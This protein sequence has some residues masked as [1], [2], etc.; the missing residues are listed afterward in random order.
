[1]N[2]L[3]LEASPGWGGQEIRILS[4]AKGMKAKGHNVILAVASYGLL[5]ERARKEGFI[6]YEINFKKRWWAFS[7]FRLMRLIWRHDIDVINTHS[8]LDSWLGG[9]V[10]RL[11]NRSIVRTRHLSAT[12]RKGWNSR[13]LYNYLADFVVTT[14]E[15][16]ANIISAQSGK[17]QK[18]CLSIPTGVNSALISFSKEESLNFRKRLNIKQT[19]CLVGMVCFM[20]SWKGVKDFLY[21]ASILRGKKDIKWVI[22]GG[23]HAYIYHKLAQELKLEDQVTFVGHLENPYFAIEALDVFTLLST[24]N[25]GVSQASLQ[26]AYLQKPLI[27]TSVGGLW[28]VCIDKVTGIQVPSFSPKKVAEAILLLKNDHELREKMGKEAKKLVQKNFTHE[29]MIEKMEK[30]YQ[31]VAE[32]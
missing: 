15:N 20:R 18:L 16:A 4:E 9:L 11:L 22:I 32:E 29:L 2:I 6:V 27:T 5:V 14:C 21:A 30:V 17:P 8:S 1:M 19:D 23:G 3:H 31:T 13:V 26:A 12:I 28:E 24:A 10:G 25:E 7:I